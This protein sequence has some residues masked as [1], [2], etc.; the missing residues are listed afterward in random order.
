MAQEIELHVARLK[1][2]VARQGRR[3]AHIQGMHQDWRYEDDQLL[4]AGRHVIEPAGSP[5]NR[6]IAPQG[7]TPGVTAE[8]ILNQAR[9]GECLA[10][11]NT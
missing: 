7:N 1:H 9:H 10:L 4:L 6:Q 2:V 11:S 5:N 8:I 3:L